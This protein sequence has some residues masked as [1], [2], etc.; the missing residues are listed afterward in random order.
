MET[1]SSSDERLDFKKVCTFSTVPGNKVY[2][3]GDGHFVKLAIHKGLCNVT[4]RMIQDDSVAKRKMISRKIQ[5]G[6]RQFDDVK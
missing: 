5:N 3:G 6:K 2:K 1:C 4:N